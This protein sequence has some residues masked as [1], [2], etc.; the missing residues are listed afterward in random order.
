M[1]IAFVNQPIDTILPPYQSSVGACTYG[2][3]CSLARS[4][5]VVVYGTK[6][7]NKDSPSDF[8][9]ED[10]H[11]KLLSLPL[12][13][14]LTASVREKYTKVFPLNTPASSSSWLYQGFGRQ[15]ARDLQQQACDVIHLQHCSQYAPNI[16]ALNPSA[17]IV[18]H[19]HAEWLSQNKPA[20]LERRLRHV[21]LVTA[22]SDHI[23]RK[24]R[25]QFPMISGRCETI[26]NG[27]DATEF[28]REKHYSAASHRPEKRLLYA[29]A[30][31]PHKGLHVLLDAFSIVA[32]QYPQVRLDVVG[33]QSS[34]PF[35]ECFDV[36]EQQVIKSVSPFYAK[37]R[38]SRLKAKLCLA[39]RDEGTYL[40]HLKSRAAAETQGKVFFHG[41][42]PRPDLIDLYYDADVFVFPPIWD[43]GFGIPPVEAMAAG[44]PVVATRSGAIPE[45]VRDQY[46]GFLVNKNDA[47]GL[48]D[49]ILKLLRNDSLRETM[50]K[51][52]RS[53]AHEYFTWDQV[54]QKM[55]KRYVALCAIGA[56][57]SVCV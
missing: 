28:S 1:K 36:Q 10:I 22:V 6:D 51:A 44:V 56:P 9:K 5:G 4:C 12:S 18:L 41:L 29:G 33:L 39:P 25:R 30:L 19:L 48:A 55:Y 43:E 42:V 21:D 47:Q 57:E 49:R 46:T 14:R 23:T 11:F 52:A 24:T 16:R 20:V 53:W 45:T 27:I 38:M 3:A 35:A 17:K 34:Y 50:G 8:W 26:Y 2:V 13:D 40:A 7:H 37:N 15:V 54:A 31:S 32:K